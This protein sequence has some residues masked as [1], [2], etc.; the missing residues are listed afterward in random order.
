MKKLCLFILFA[1][2]LT[3]CASPAAEPE[4]EAPQPMETLSRESLVNQNEPCWTEQE[5]LTA[6]YEYAEAGTVVIDCV[7]FEESACSVVGVVQYTREN[8]NGCWFDFI[9]K[10]GIPRSTGTEATPVEEKTLACAG[11]D[12]VR[13]RLLDENGEAFVC[14]VSYFEELDEKT[15]GFK[16]VSR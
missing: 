1:F 12:T 11:V 6:F 13:C 2:L 8:E 15:T 7:A 9:K 5:L 16:L 14:E 3:G 10:E 4:Q